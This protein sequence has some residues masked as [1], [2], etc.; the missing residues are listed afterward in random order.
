[1][2]EL[3]EPSGNEITQNSMHGHLVIFVELTAGIEEEI[4]QKIVNHIMLS[5]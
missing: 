1:M 3:P 5:I 2:A 4:R